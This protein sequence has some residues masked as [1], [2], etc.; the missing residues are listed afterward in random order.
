MD[1]EYS[2]YGFVSCLNKK[3]RTT[4]SLEKLLIV[5]P[6]LEGNMDV[7]VAH[8]YSTGD[9]AALLQLNRL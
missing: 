3:L 4:L 9:C 2:S 6:K 8:L 5:L 1:G 7:D